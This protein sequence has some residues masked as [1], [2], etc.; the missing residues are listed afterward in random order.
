WKQPMRAKRPNVHRTEMLQALA[1]GAEGTCNFQWSKSPGN[2]EKFHG[3]VVEQVGHE[4]TR[5]VRAVAELGREYERLGAVLG[6]ATPAE[7]ALVYDWEVHWAF[8][9]SE[10]PDK[11]NAAYDRVCV[12]HYRPFW[13]AGISVDVLDSNRSFDG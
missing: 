9:G 6:S 12:E 8:D 3:A 11:R 10:G 1:H 13:E 5:G 4:Q 2:C 7:V